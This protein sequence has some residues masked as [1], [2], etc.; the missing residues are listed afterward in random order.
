MLC[1]AHRSSVRFLLGCCAVLLAASACSEAD[2]ARD[3]SAP[4]LQTTV[5]A[6]SAEADPVPGAPPYF[7]ASPGWEAV[8][9]GSGATV[10]NVSLGPDAVEGNIPASET[11]ERLEAGDVLL[12]AMFVPIGDTEAVDAAFQ[13][14]ELPLSLDDAVTDINFEGQ[15]EHIYADRL[16]AQVD[17][18]NIDVLIFYGGGDPTAVPPVRAQPSADTRAAAQAQLDL[19]VIP[20]RA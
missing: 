8:Q 10:G 1:V 11:I 4:T 15:P 2:T 13:A 17:G 14:R 18:W 6:S 12:Q 3:R 5:T 7:Q 9:V 19:L 16:G 20:P